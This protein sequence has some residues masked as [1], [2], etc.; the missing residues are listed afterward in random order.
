MGGVSATREL[1]REARGLP[2][3]ENLVQQ[4]SQAWRSWRNAK[5]V[6]VLA[7]G[8]LALGIGS[9]TAIYT[10]VDA[11]MLKPLPYRDGDR[12]VALF[13]ADLRDPEHFSLLRAEDAEKYQQRTQLF[14]AFGW[15]RASGK[16]LTFAGEPHHVDGVAVTVPLVHDLGVEPALGHW[17]QDDSGAVISHSLWQRLG[18]DA[19]IIGKA[20]TLDG[21]RYTVTGVMPPSFHLPVPGITSGG[22]EADV[23][24]PLDPHERAGPAYIAYGRRKP[25]VTFAA[26]EADVTRVAAEIAAEDPQNHQAYAARLNDLRETVVRYIRPTLLLLFGAAGLLFLITCANAAGLLL[27]R[28]VTRARETA[29]RV[30]LG[31][32]RWQLAVHYFAEGL[33][34]S[35]AGAIGG[36]ILS[37]TLTSAIV[38][39]AADYLPR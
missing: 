19:E 9:T 36:I 5:A 11:V 10:V 20:L 6:A 8:A 23:W 17:F 24:M 29:M 18:A 31:A 4:S 14:D 21:R 3:I 27:A 22:I 32:S 35:L 25:G 30:A 2:R 13:S 1:H 7:A 28:S 33:L 16:N 38:S 34:I 15:F 39:L 12:F 26:A 37:L